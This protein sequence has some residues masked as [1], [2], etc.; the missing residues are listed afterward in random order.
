MKKLLRSPVPRAQSLLSQQN[1]YTQPAASGRS[2]SR[3][4]ARWLQT[5]VMLPLYLECLAIC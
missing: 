2:L 5:L 3:D 1:G 4:K